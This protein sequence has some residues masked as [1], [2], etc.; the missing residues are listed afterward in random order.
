MQSRCRRVAAAT[1][2]DDLR[3]GRAWSCVGWRRVTGR[4]RSPL[5]D[6]R[7]V[8][9]HVDCEDRSWHYAEDRRK[10]GEQ[11]SSIRSR[12][13]ACGEVSRPC[14]SYRRFRWNRR[15]LTSVG[16]IRTIRSAARSTPMAPRSAVG[17]D[18]ARLAR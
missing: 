14:P 9:Q 7:P 10:R 11:A 3:A 13:L 12:G 4:E 17:P 5:A 6:Q 18:A 2:R 8:E 16:V 15:P 1:T